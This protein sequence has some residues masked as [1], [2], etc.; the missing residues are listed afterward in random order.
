MEEVVNITNITDNMCSPIL[1][2]LINLTHIPAFTAQK[3]SL[4]LLETRSP[5]AIKWKGNNESGALP[6]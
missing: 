5:H 4:K 1:I 6:Y 3:I 2:Q